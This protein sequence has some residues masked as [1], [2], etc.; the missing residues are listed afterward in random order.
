MVSDVQL[1][2]QKDTF[3][4][5]AQHNGKVLAHSMYRV[6]AVPNVI[7]HNHVLWKLEIPLKN[8]IFIWYLIK[9]VA[10]SKG[11]LAKRHR[12]GTSKCC[13]CNMDESIQ[14]TFSGNRPSMPSSPKPAH[15]ASQ[16]TAPS[17]GQFGPSA[18]GALAGLPFPLWV[19]HSTHESLSH[20]ATLW[21]P[22]V[23]PL[24]HLLRCPSSTALPPPFVAPSH[25]RRPTQH[26]EMPP[27]CLNSPPH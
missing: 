18:F 22:P 16:A 21:A 9:G 14:Q 12:K 1:M 26:Q 13:F 7:P 11:N 25:H 2:C 23:G 3:I 5:A 17:L 19:A 8:K 10:L 15:H 20:V 6:L 4:W 27:P 24:F